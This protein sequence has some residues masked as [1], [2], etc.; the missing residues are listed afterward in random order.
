MGN[1]VHLVPPTVALRAVP[2]TDKLVIRKML[3]TYL[4][5]LEVSQTYPYFELYWSE[6]GRHPLLISTNDQIAGFAL[7]RPQTAAA[8]RELAEF[9]VL[10]E[11]RRRGIGQTAF[12]QLMAAFPGQWQVR[13]SGR[14]A[15]A[16]QFWQA[17]VP[18]SSL[19]S[20][21]GEAVVFT[22]SIGSVAA[23]HAV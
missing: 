16:Q 23:A 3:S 19:R 4:A 9:Y 22:F 21:E 10:P 2:P 5:E 17:V 20:A 6:S 18:E 8:G 15:T 13:V 1:D 7:V 11:Y 14:N 12:R